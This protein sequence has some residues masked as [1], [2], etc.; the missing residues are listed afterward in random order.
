[1]GTPAYSAPELWEGRRVDRRCDVFSLGVVLHELVAGERPF[2]GSDVTE[3]RRAIDDGEVPSSGH[4]L[5]DPV[6]RRAVAADP[7]ARYSS[8]G[9]AGGRSDCVAPAPFAVR[10]SPR[11]VGPDRRRRRQRGLVGRTPLASPPLTIR[12]D[13]ALRPLDL[14]PRPLTKTGG[15]VRNAM[16]VQR[17]Y[18]VYD[19][20]RGSG[21]DLYRV[22][23]SGGPVERLTSGPTRKWRGASGVESPYVVFVEDYE[24]LRWIDAFTGS[25]VETV[26]VPA[27][28][29]GVTPDGY[30]YVRG[31]GQEI[32]RVTEAGEEVLVNLPA[33]L[34]A[35]M[36][37]VAP[38]GSRVAFTPA[39]VPSSAG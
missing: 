6:I 38:D 13:L 14:A 7:A 2:R 37:S 5:L 18:V 8:C 21:T 3:V 36:M 16:F 23:F 26:D 29:V 15:C 34:D 19:L 12:P 4:L 31:S 11:R 24:R 39:W 33:P 28:A 22:S 20:Q 27:E 9:H 1:M 10:R 17:G 30:I 35:S 25:I 32:R